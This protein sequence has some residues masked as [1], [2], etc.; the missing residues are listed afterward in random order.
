MHLYVMFTVVQ[1]CEQI[2]CIAS[3][4]FSVKGHH[5]NFNERNSHKAFG[6]A[7]HTTNK[8]TGIKPRI[9]L[10]HWT[11]QLFESKHFKDFHTEVNV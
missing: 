5:R 2:H 7:R 1:Y 8:Q 11:S 3:N 9:T 10:S 4:P 6:Q